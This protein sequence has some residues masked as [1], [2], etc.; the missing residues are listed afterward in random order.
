MT[1]LTQRCGMQRHAGRR[2]EHHETATT[3]AHGGVGI[4]EHEAGLRLPTGGACNHAFKPAVRLD[5]TPRRNAREVQGHAD[6]AQALRRIE[7]GP[8]ARGHRQVGLQRESTPMDRASG[9]DAVRTR[10]DAQ[11]SATIG[12]LIKRHLEK[13]HREVKTGCAIER[14]PPKDLIEDSRFL[15]ACSLN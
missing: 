15:H 8:N 12:D 10:V 9:I 11:V 3:E 5:A 14:K 1:A 7:S 2:V 13:V 6:S 4:A